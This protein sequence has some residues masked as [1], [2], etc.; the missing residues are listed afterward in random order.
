MAFWWARAPLVGCLACSGRGGLSLPAWRVSACFWWGRSTSQARR[1]EP[2]T[3]PGVRRHLR[4]HLA[5]CRRSGGAWWSCA[6][7]GGVVRPF[8]QLQLVLNYLAELGTARHIGGTCRWCFGAADHC[9]QPCPGA[10]L[11]PSP[12]GQG[13]AC[14]KDTGLLWS[15]LGGASVGSVPACCQCAPRASACMP[16]VAF[17]RHPGDGFPSLRGVAEGSALRWSQGCKS[18]AVEAPAGGRLAAPNLGA[19]GGGS[20][21]SG[22]WQRPQRGF[23]W[24]LL[25]RGRGGVGGVQFGPRATSA[26]RLSPPVGL[27]RCVQCCGSAMACVPP[28]GVL[29]PPSPRRGRANWLG[30]GRGAI[31][32]RSVNR[33]GAHALGCGVPTC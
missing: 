12:C 22:D 31:C 28:S 7:R 17:Q 26:A 30:L 13:W 4:H 9:T 1:R 21:A 29:A 5:P 32:G 8:P 3:L 27:L 20:P 23:C 19:A 10:A 14:A 2:W 16:V 11:Q 18:F 33:P 6:C 24:A 15:S 25:C